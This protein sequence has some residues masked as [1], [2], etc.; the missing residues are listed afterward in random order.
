MMSLYVNV[1]FA[2]VQPLSAGGDEAG[3]R[4][5]R[6]PAQILRLAAPFCQAY[7][8][9]MHEAARNDYIWD[10]LR[11]LTV[12]RQDGLWR[13]ISGESP[14]DLGEAIF[15]FRERDGWTA[16]IPYRAEPEHI[17]RHVRFDL[18]VDTHI[19]PAGLGEVIPAILRDAEI[20]CF[21][22]DGG[23]R[24]AIFVV[25]SDAEHT[26]AVLRRLKVENR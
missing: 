2:H 13:F 1:R 21:F 9:I 5:E 26:E 12:E 25:E 3:V 17:L 14:P 23:W 24:S 4:R 6:S 16:I 8:S 19:H 11:T 7:A 18:S 15:A 10:L 22:V 20:S